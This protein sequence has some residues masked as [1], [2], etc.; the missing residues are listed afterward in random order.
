[1]NILVQILCHEKKA[2]L[3]VIECDAKGVLDMDAYRNAFNPKTKMVALTHISNV[4]GTINPAKE[5][6][7]IAKSHQVPILIDGAQAAAHIPVDIS[8]LDPD[9]YTAS[10]HKMYGPTGVGFLY[11]KKEHLKGMSPYQSGG[12][13]IASVSFDDIT[14]LEGPMRFEAGTPHIAGSIGF[15][16]A[17]EYMMDVGMSYIQSHEQALLMYLQE[18]IETVDGLEVFGQAPNKIGIV[19]FAMKG[20]H[21]H[22]IAS[23]LDEDEVAVRAGHHCAMPLVKSMNQPALTRISL[24]LNNNERDIDQCIKSL[25]KV[26][27]IFSA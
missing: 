17:C 7:A 18:Q 8:D 20:V 19:S 5:M 3:V 6:I 16:R 1:M 21:P 22:D 13:M 24:G 23:I 2:K 14:Y 26:R 10:A 4:L 27:E 15:A 11:V 12:N 25:K 9:F